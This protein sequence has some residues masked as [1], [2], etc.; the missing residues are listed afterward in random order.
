MA[1][2]PKR[3]DLKNTRRQYT[4]VFRAVN[5]ELFAKPVRRDSVTFCTLQNPF[6]SKCSVNRVLKLLAV[7]RV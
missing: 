3:A 5:F 4:S 7:I 6:S 2:D 1:D